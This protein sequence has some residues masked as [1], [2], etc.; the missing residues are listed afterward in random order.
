VLHGLL[1]ASKILK[2][3]KKILPAAMPLRMEAALASFAL[4]ASVA[5]LAYKFVF[6]YYDEI[7]KL[8]CLP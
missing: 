1:K 5:A 8:Q 6:V 3:K 4:A 2:A 7:V